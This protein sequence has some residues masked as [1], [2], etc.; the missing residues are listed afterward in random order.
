MSGYSKPQVYVAGSA[1]ADIAGAQVFAGLSGGVDSALTCALL[2]EAG[3]QVTA[4]YMRNWSRD[5]PGF[6]CPWARDLADAERTAVALGI[7]LEV[8]DFEED[9]RRYVVDELVAGYAAGITPN[10]DVA[11]NERV[12]FGTFLEQA[13]ERGADLVATG[14]Y[15][16]LGRSA[17][18]ATTLLRS[19][20]E[21]KDQTYFLWRVGK[22]ALA[23]TAFPIGNIASKDEVRRLAAE[24][25]LEVAQKPDS[26]G[27]CCVGPVGMR[28]FLLEELERTPGDVIEWGTGKVL[29]RHEGAFLFTVG[30]R[31]GLGLGGGPARYVVA[32]DASTNTVIVTDD[33]D[34][35]DLWMDRL[36]LTNTRWVAGEK[37][38]EGPCEV[39]CRHTAPL[40]SGFLVHTEEGAQVRLDEQTPAIAPGQSIVVY[41]GWE[42]LGGGVL[43]RAFKQ[44]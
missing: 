24:R 31:K 9:Y 11:C 23:H 35:P 13:L 19:A 30:Q 29:G 27:V 2:A 34:C 43:T 22:D 6:R 33:P 4:V 38:E 1:V 12:K 20:D 8:W 41:R 26:D 39:R 14:H 36:Q 15:A 21:H 44:S 5:L 37:P 25:G 10:P 18:G 32:T 3:A 17:S 16:A 28:T 42:C 40:R 7:D